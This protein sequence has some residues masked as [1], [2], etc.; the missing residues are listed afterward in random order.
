M[1]RFTSIEDFRMWANP[2][3]LPSGRVSDEQCGIRA[4]RLQ[5][6]VN[7][8]KSRLGI[9]FMKPGALDEYLSFPDKDDSDPVVNKFSLFAGKMVRFVF[10]PPRYTVP[11]FDG[12]GYFEIVSVNDYAKNY[13]AS[14]FGFGKVSMIEVPFYT[15]TPHADRVSYIIESV[16]DADGIF[17]AIIK[18]DLGMNGSGRALG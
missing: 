6:V 9:G 11:G 8:I 12:I 2:D 3:G 16:E 4:Y 14:V 1:K 10:L 18:E 13:V 5:T 15:Q 7:V 17:D